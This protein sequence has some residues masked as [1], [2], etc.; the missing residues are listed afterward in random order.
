MAK[1]WRGTLLDDPRRRLRAAVMGAEAALERGPNHGLV[2][3]DP[4][5]LEVLVEGAKILGDHLEAGLVVWPEGAE[6]APA[7]AQEPE[8]EVPTT[9]EAG[10]GSVRG[11]EGQILWPSFPVGP[12]KLAE[13]VVLEPG[14]GGEVSG[15]VRVPGEDAPLGWTVLRQAQVA[16]ALRYL[17]YLNTEAWPQGLAH[18]DP[19]DCG[20][21]EIVAA[22]APWERPSVQPATGAEVSDDLAERAAAFFE[23]RGANDP[24]APHHVPLPSDDPSVQPLLAMA[25]DVT[26]ILAALIHERGVVAQLN[27][28]TADDDALVSQAVRMVVQVNREVSGR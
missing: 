8:T 14:A 17:A 24:D 25:R 13:G 5:A 2:C 27:G 26:R 16:L 22:V 7:N 20:A 6:K 1:D 23:G 10:G 21:L 15:W 11:S 4:R 18:P 3:L 28:P 12:W 19:D 9:P